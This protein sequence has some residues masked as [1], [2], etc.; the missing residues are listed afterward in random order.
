MF[1]NLCLQRYSS[2]SEGSVC[3]S[4]CVLQ[5]RIDHDSHNERMCSRLAEASSKSGTE[6][7]TPSLEAVSTAVSWDILNQVGLLLWR[8]FKSAENIIFSLWNILKQTT[9]NVENAGW[10]LAGLFSRW[11]ADIDLKK[12]IFHLWC[13]VFHNTPQSTPTS[14]PLGVLCTLLDHQQGLA[15][16]IS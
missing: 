8:A 4:V 12:K 7:K 1:A 9:A 14:F 15:W 13:L 16:R 6:S 3:A 11:K 10:I 2:S 5:K